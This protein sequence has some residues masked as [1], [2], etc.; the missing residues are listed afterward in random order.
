MPGQVLTGMM[1]GRIPHLIGRADKNR[2]L[3][4]PGFCQPVDL[5]RSEHLHRV[6]QFSRPNDHQ[7]R[8]G[9]NRIIDIPIFQVELSCAKIGK[10]I[11]SIYVIINLHPGIPLRDLID[12]SVMRELRPIRSVPYSGIS[13]EYSIFIWIDPPPPLML[14]A[15]GSAYACPIPAS[16]HGMPGRYG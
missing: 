6:Q 13:K 2:F 7:V 8:G 14:P 12:P 5:F 1:S 11:P 3:T 9:G 10:D 4:H 16:P 15:D